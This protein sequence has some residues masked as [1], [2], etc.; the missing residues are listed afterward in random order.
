MK[1]FEVKG[2]SC[3]GCVK[4]VERVVSALEGV[5]AVIVTLEPG[6]VEVE[7]SVDAGRVV[8]VIENAGFS[9]R[10]V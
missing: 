7:G 1:S 10:P 2:M 4:S 9:A 5:R 8:E 3:Q 6:K